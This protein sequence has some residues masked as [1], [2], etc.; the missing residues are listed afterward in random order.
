MMYLKW[1]YFFLVHHHR[2]DVL[3]LLV[4]NYLHRR[5]RRRLR[6]LLRNLLQDYRIQFLL[7]VVSQVDLFHLDRLYCVNFLHHI[8]LIGHQ[9]LP[10]LL[11]RLRH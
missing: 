7:K 5:Q 1:N 8:H 9:D 4:Q 6:V 2:L 10:K 3:D 11:L